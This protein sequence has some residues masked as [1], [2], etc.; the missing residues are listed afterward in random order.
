MLECKR[1]VNFA[2]GLPRVRMPSSLSVFFGTAFKV[3]D[4]FGHLLSAVSRAV[5]ISGAVK[6]CSLGFCGGDETSTVVLLD[7]S[8]GF[9][10]LS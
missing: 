7:G 3:Q 9:T 10:G 6:S 1:V 2:N 5:C 4:R 8:V